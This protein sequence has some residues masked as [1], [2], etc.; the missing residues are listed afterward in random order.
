MLCQSH[1]R[2]Y[3]AFSLEE[4]NKSIQLPVPRRVTA[5][6][7]W[8]HPSLEKVWLKK[9]KLQYFHFAFFF[10]FSCKNVFLLLEAEQQLWAG[11]GGLHPALSLTGTGPPAHPWPPR[12][13]GWR[14]L[15]LPTFL[16]FSG[17]AF[18]KINCR[19]YQS[20]VSCVLS[21]AWQN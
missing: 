10:F 11:S 1:L 9:C 12:R 7:V 3:L 6:W 16:H 20:S 19:L 5:G 15:L 13:A 8:P 17:S 14:L 2:R 4:S 18:Y 21:M